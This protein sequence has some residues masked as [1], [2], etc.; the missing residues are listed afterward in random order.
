VTEAN[1]LAVD[2]PRDLGR[3][4]GWFL[5]LGIGLIDQWWAAGAFNG[6]DFVTEVPAY[7]DN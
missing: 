2:V 6:G 7:L 1:V 3:S 4:W 5:A